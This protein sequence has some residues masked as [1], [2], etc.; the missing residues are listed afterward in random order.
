MLTDLTRQERKDV[1][2]FVGASKK[3]RAEAA[4]PV[5]TAA[6]KSVRTKEHEARLSLSLI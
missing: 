2:T 1:F 6:F 5:S 4:S 3:I